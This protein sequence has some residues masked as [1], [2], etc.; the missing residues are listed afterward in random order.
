MNFTCKQTAFILIVPWVKIRAIFNCIYIISFRNT[1]F[2]FHRDTCFI[3]V[4][5]PRVSHHIYTASGLFYD[6]TA[7]NSTIKW[8][9]LHVRCL[10][11]WN[12][13]A[14]KWNESAE[15]GA[16]SQMKRGRYLTNTR[17]FNSTLH[18]WCALYKLL[19]CT[20]KSWT[21]KSFAWVE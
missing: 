10:Y 20:A 14:T 13:S 18:F 12:L 19:V 17:R 3:V 1:C 16:S 5:S 8:V 4:K 21:G 6:I 2:P 9:T 7:S 11:K 15:Q